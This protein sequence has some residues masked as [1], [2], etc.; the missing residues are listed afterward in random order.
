MNYLVAYMPDAYLRDIAEHFAK[1]RPAFEPKQQ[2]A[3]TPEVIERGAT[4]ALSGD[5][6]QADPAL[7][8]LPRSRG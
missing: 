3:A 7:H 5:A 2:P 4:I 1:Q 8:R 6:E